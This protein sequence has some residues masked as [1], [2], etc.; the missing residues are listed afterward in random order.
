MRNKRIGHRDYE[1][2]IQPNENP[3]PGITKDQ[4]ENILLQA[5][6]IL[7]FVLKMYDDSEMYFHAV[8]PGEGYVLINLLRKSKETLQN[9]RSAKRRL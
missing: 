8:S 4:I 1:T 5:A 6:D 2:V 7:N 3:L 9:Q